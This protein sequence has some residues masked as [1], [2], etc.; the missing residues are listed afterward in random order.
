MI[1]GRCGSPPRVPSRAEPWPRKEGLAPPAPTPAWE[2]VTQE[3]PLGSRPR[4]P[5]GGRAEHPVSTVRHPPGPAGHPHSGPSSLRPSCHMRHTPGAQPP[6]ATVAS[7]GMHARR[8]GSRAALRSRHEGTR[9]PGSTAHGGPTSNK[10]P[11]PTERGTP[12]QERHRAAEP[13]PASPGGKWWAGLPRAGPQCAGAHGRGRLAGAAQVEPGLGRGRAHSRR[14]HRPQGR[15]QTALSE[16]RREDLSN[17]DRKF[18]L[19]PQPLPTHVTRHSLVSSTLL[20]PSQ[21][22]DFLN[23]RKQKV[24]RNQ[25]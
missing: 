10:R 8:A 19:R 17:G 20:L 9:G 21:M 6:P 18:T 11:D 3:V 25:N 13:A 23:T 2:R 14:G 4:A 16:V 15:P 12:G 7:G 22:A 1:P 24:L 5:W